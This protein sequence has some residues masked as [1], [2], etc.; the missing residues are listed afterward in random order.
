MPGRCTSLAFFEFLF[1]GECMFCFSACNSFHS[2]FCC[3]PWK[4]DAARESAKFGCVFPPACLP[5]HDTQDGD[6]RARAHQGVSVMVPRRRR[7]VSSGTS[8]CTG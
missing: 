8:L 5:F 7:L 6:A 2:V 1:V 4:E 3:A